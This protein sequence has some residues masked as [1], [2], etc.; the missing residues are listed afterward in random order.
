MSVNRRREER[1]FQMDEISN[2]YLLNELSIFIKV[3][4]SVLCTSVKQVGRP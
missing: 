1:E 2:N 4:H 3:L